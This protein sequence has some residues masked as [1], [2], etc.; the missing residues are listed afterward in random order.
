MPTADL[1]T[2]D[3]RDYSH[4]NMTPHFGSKSRALRPVDG[5]R[6]ATMDT[7]SGAGSLHQTKQSQAPLFAPASALTNPYGMESHTNEYQQYYQ[8]VA[9]TSMNGVALPAQSEGRGIG[10]A[11]GEGPG[12]AYVSAIDARDALLPR[13]VD[14]LRAANNPKS[15]E[16]SLGGL[17]GA[18]GGYANHRPDHAPVHKNRPET[19]AEIGPE[20]YFT[21]VGLERAPTARAYHVEKFTNRTETDA[22]SGYVGAAGGTGEGVLHA[23]GAYLMDIEHNPTSRQELGALPIGIAAAAGRSGGSDQDYL[24]NGMPVY[25]TNRSAMPQDAYFGSGFADAIG[26]VVAPLLDALRPT[27]KQNTVAN[28]RP[29]GAGKAQVASADFRTPGMSLPPTIRDQTM[30]ANYNHM[31]AVNA[32]ANSDGYTIAEIQ[33]RDNARATTS[34]V[35][36]TGNAQSAHLRP[37]MQEDV[38]FRPDGQKVQTLAG[39]MVPGVSPAFAGPSNFGHVAYRG[40]GYAET[41][42]SLGAPAQAARSTPHSGQIGEFQTRYAQPAD[43]GTSRIDPALMSE[44]FR[45]NPYV[46]RPF[47]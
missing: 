34:G 9:S 30:V 6:D 38:D 1:S 20:R 22:S 7:Y 21:D 25:A 10:K 39:R 11:V 24:R 17:E 47:G 40:S 42:P 4:T 18:A 16:H 15:S 14:E 43:Q 12:G 2:V 5:Q 8:R 23:P 35:E 28:L 32:L 29:Y 27:R 44:A 37:R 45:N 46:H 41:T 33:L 36:Y 26:A 19:F 3:G 31:P 13:G